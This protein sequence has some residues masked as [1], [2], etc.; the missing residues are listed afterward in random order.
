MYSKL[1]WGANINKKLLI[2]SLMI[3]LFAS[4]GCVT[5][6]DMGGNSTFTASENGSEHVSAPDGVKITME[7]CLFPI[8]M[9]T[10][11]MW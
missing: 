7:C 3:I 5:A 6:Q 11:V 4:I 9:K 10:K 8:I 1:F 2:L